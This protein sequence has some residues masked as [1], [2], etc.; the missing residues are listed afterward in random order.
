MK[1]IE[2]ICPKC[3]GKSLTI[4]YYEKG[5]CIDNSIKSANYFESIFPNSIS[6]T[7]ES[8]FL[9]CKCRTCNYKWIEK[10]I[11]S[12]NKPVET[13]GECCIK[14]VKDIPA[15]CY[16][17]QHDIEFNGILVEGTELRFVTN[18]FCP[19]SNR[20]DKH[21]VECLRSSD[22]CHFKIKINNLNEKEIEWI[23][24]LTEIHKNH[25]ILK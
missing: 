6:D 11:F 14:D 24:T 20:H 12:Q 3:G 16:Y 23:K 5:E 13:D 9:Y 10:P 19:F 17:T 7:A 8:E 18:I 1:R 25:L 4:R 21:I 22:D 15:L 2:R